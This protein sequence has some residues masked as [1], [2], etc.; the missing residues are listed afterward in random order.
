MY[1]YL[2]NIEELGVINS[3]C[4]LRISKFQTTFALIQNLGRNFENSA[5]WYMQSSSW[6]TTAITKHLT[7]PP[8]CVGDRRAQFFSFVDSQLSNVVW[9][10]RNSFLIGG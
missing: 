7:L 9:K 10:V 6:A 8:F 4:T 5:L 3:V 2:Q 1:E